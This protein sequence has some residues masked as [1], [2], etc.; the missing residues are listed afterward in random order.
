MID[1]LIENGALLTSEGW[2]GNGHLAISAGKISALGPGPLSPDLSRSAKQT[3]SAAG[4]VVLPGLTN[5]H[6]HLSQSLMR[7]LAAGR[8]L[9]TWLNEVIWPLQQHMTVE[10]LSLSALLGLVENL[11][12]GATHIV[13][14]QKITHSPACSLAVIQAAQQAGVRLTLAHAWADR[15]PHAGDPQIILS[16]LTALFKQFSGSDRV[17]IASG[18][19][20]PWRASP[21]V[22]QKTHALALDYGGVTHIHVSETRAEV[23]TSLQET[24]MRPVAWLDSLGVLSPASQIVHAVWVDADEIQLLQQRGACVVHCPTSNAVLGSGMAPVTAMLQAGIPIRLGTDGAASNDTQDAFENMKMALCLG[25][26]SQLDPSQLSPARVLHMASAGKTLAVGA[27]ADLLLLN[28]ESISS[29]PVHDLDS[30][31]VLS[32]RSGD[33]DTVIVDG[34]VLLRHK[35][36]TFLDEA[37]LIRDCRQASANLLKRAAI[38]QNLPHPLFQASRV[39]QN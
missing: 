9:S 35:C 39:G 30:A 4:M 36:I 17:Q 15:G 10:D 22:L 7:G 38:N 5:A 6:T 1:I 28:L 25:R 13:D 29:A 31:I 3:L 32:A 21:A 12:S 34:K 23:Q 18:P 19:L 33:V 14:H 2:C 11:H 26:L 24:G 16:E 27:P 20:T 37:Q 8:S